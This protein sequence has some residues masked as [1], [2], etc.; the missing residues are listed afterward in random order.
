MAARDRSA[1]RGADERSV[2]DVKS[3]GPGIPTLMP[4]SPGMMIRRVTVAT[5]RH[6]GESAYKREDHRAGNAGMSRLN[7]W[8]L[9]PAFF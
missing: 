7:L 8:Y 3:R 6:T 9:P 2:A 1:L 4:S 5:S